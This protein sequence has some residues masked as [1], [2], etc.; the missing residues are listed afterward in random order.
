MRVRD[1]ARLLQAMNGEVVEFELQSREVPDEILE[2]DLSSSSGFQFADQVPA[3]AVAERI[4]VEINSEAGNEDDQDDPD[5]QLY[6]RHAA[7]RFVGFVSHRWLLFH[8][9]GWP[10]HV[11]RQSAHVRDVRGF[12]VEPGQRQRRIK[13]L[14]SALGSKRLQPVRNERIDPLLAQD[15]LDLVL[16]L[17]QR[18]RRRQRLLF[19][20]GNKLRVV[21][22]LHRA[23]S[24]PDLGT[25]TQ[26]DEAQRLNLLAYPARDIFFGKPVLREEAMP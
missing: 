17:I 10:G 4:A 16:Y 12:L 19:H 25:E 24:D 20:F 13:R 3:H 18:R 8:G 15:S 9:L 26:I 22:S 23:R 2:L 11:Q 6:P 5:P 14:N 21:V 1:L 7:R